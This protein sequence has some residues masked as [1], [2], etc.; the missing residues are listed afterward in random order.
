MVRRDVDTAWLS[1]NGDRDRVMWEKSYGRC[2]IEGSKSEINGFM[3][4]EG[5]G[6]AASVK[7][8]L[9]PV[10]FVLDVGAGCPSSQ[11]SVE[12]CWCGGTWLGAWVE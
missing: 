6:A 7:V 12:L 11:R 8:G 4:M 9:V 3:E 10:V 1:P 5:G 2:L